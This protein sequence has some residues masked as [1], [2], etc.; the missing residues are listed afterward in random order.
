MCAKEWSLV[1]PVMTVV[2]SCGV[3]AV[4]LY[5]LCL[6]CLAVSCSVSSISRRLVCLPMPCRFMSSL[7]V[8]YLPSGDLWYLV[9][10]VLSRIVFS[11]CWRLML[12]VLSVLSVLWCLVVSL[13][14]TGALRSLVVSCLSGGAL[15]CLV[16]PIRW[17]RTVLVCLLMH[18]RV[19]WSLVVCLSSLSLIASWI[20]SK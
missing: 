11:V 4:S 15:R 3:A 8:S 14:T 19:L 16:L 13:L 10:L 9:C 6:F 7:D 5:L 12:S 18:C 20:L 2:A 1:C 17:C